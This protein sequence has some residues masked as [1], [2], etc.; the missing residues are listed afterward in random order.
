MKLRIRD[1]KLDEFL[2]GLALFIVGIVLF[3]K[4]IYVSSSLLTHGLKV[5]GIYLRSG[6]CVIPFIIGVILMFIKPENLFPKI[7]SG[8]GF[9]FIIAVAIG[10]VNIRV[11]AI[12]IVKWLIM[13]LLIFGGIILMCSAVYLRGKKRR[14]K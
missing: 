7:L 12:P 8:A 4:N 5:G 1:D 2:L 14:K 10:S 9:L 6:I 13:L 11:R 3:T